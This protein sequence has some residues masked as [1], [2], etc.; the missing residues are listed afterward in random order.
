ML[1]FLGAL[2]L[3]LGATAVNAPN[4]VRATPGETPA[5][6][7]EGV[8]VEAAKRRAKLV[9]NDDTL[10]YLL[11][12]A[13][14]R[15][16]NTPE[17][18]GHNGR[19]MLSNRLGAHAS[20]ADIQAKK[21]SGAAIPDN[22]LGKD[23]ILYNK[24]ADS[25]ILAHELGH[26]VSSRTDVGKQVRY[27]RSN[28]ELARAGLLAGVLAPVGISAFTPGDDD[29]AASV[30]V[31]YGASIPTLIDEALATK[32]GFAI[33]KDAGMPANAKQRARMAG[34]YLTYA[35]APLLGG[36][37]FNKFGNMFDEDIPNENI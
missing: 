19:L 36:I 32:N 15:P 14:T 34:A 22:I 30:A 21:D 10:D 20:A 2:G 6:G 13:P 23:I 29:M 35:T 11:E 25:A 31:A 37:G 3:N 24:N 12:A 1:D 27:L 16:N 33:M 26:G 7:N 17:N 18:I 28:P 4:M 8:L 5:G 9:A